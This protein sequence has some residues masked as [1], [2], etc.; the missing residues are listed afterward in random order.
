MLSQMR[1]EAAGTRLASD[2]A[3]I[4]SLR[5]VLD[6]MKTYNEQPTWFDKHYGDR[7]VGTIAYFSAEFGIHECLPIYSGGLGTLAGDHLK[8]A[9][10][11]GIPLVGV[12]LLYR[13]GYFHQ[14]LTQGRIPVRRLPGPELLAVADHVGSRQERGGN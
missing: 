6:S 5:R 3:Y 1:Q 13:Q 14:Y 11:L 8:S 2:P 10:D 7:P 9:S 4:A 12:G